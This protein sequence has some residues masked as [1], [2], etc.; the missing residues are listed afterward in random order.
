MKELDEKLLKNL[1]DDI[2]IILKNS[3]V[4]NEDEANSIN[5]FGEV[6]FFDV[7]FNSLFKDPD[8]LRRF[9]RDFA[10][11]EVTADCIEV[12]TLKTRESFKTQISNDLGFYVK[13]G[14]DEGDEFIVLVEAQ[15]TWNPNMPFRFLEYITATYGNYIDD[16]HYD[17]YGYPQFYLPRPRFC[18][19]YS[20]PGK[21]N[22]EKMMKFASMYGRKITPAAEDLNFGI[23]V[24][25][26]DESSTIAGQYVGFSGLAADLRTKCHNGVECVEALKKA[27]A[28]KG[29]DIMVQFICKNETKM[30]DAMELSIKSREIFHDYLK[31]ERQKA[32]EEA[33]EKAAPGLIKE[34]EERG[35]KI[36]EE[37][38]LERGVKIGEER[39]L[40][41][42]LERGVMR[43]V[44]DFY[45]SG[46]ITKDVALE[47]L[48]V[49]AQEFEAML[50]NPI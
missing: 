49:T 48:C 33:V 42:G 28:E 2:K 37:R 13:H 24:L 45:K 16:H 1:P 6:N 35:V 7:S 40:E 15:S 23:H 12:V 50:E 34:G 8:Y 19:I 14:D 26:T 39:G 3:K 4:Q 22:R 27:C 47:K 9:Y 11:R 43:T 38:G 25:G 18:M 10:E 5:Q 21:E 31:D 46:F 36:G 29:Y 41:R 30:V 20:G 17:K 44:I 32:A